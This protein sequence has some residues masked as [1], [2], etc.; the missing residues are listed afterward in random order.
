MTGMTGV[1]LMKKWLYPLLTLTLVSAEAIPLTHVVDN[2]VPRNIQVLLEKDI[3]ETLIEVKGP[4]YLLNPHDGSRVAS[5]LLGKR[6]MV[7]ELETG[8]KWGEEFPGIHQFYIK[9]RSAETSVFVNGIQY[10]GSIAVYGVAGMVHVIN[11]LDIESYVKAVLTAQF[12]TSLEPEVL[13]ALAIL[14]R[15]DAYYHAMKN[16][17]CFWHVTAKEV[18]YPGSALII[19]N[20]PVEK[21]VD[22]TKNL[23]LVHPEGG[24]TLPFATAWTEHSGG[25]TA[26]YEAMFRKDMSAPEKGV[27]A[28]HAALTRSESKWSYKLGK[29]S[30]A[31]L[32][33]FGQIQSVETF[34][35][36]SSNKVYGLR[37]KDGEQAKDFDFFALQEL[38]GERHIM[39]SDF[40]VSLKE[41]NIVFSGFGKGHGAGL[42]IYSASALA[43]NGEN[44][45]K[46]LAKFFPETYLYNVNAIPK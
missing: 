46:I 13:S 9:P 14:M 31:N 5:G 25:K 22:S 6:F 44:A 18:Q 15:T 40:T 34:V 8:L 36:P 1:T 10:Q 2:I 28:P 38:L 43:Q 24:H 21:A 3:S 33:N 42:C 45:V 11:D 26:S 39:S 32:I 29:K 7:R 12:P 16:E 4:Y 27:E 20:S 30:L 41:D 23:I 35:D 17:S 37:V 19:P